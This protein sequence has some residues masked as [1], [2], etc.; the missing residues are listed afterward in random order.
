ML[1]H[2]LKAFGIHKQDCIQFL[3]ERSGISFW[4][5][6][7]KLDKDLIFLTNFAQKCHLL[8]KFSVLEGMPPPPGS[9]TGVGQGEKHSKVGGSASGR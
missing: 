5:R 2:F 4:G 7:V 3:T 6:E 1:V 9:D 8:K